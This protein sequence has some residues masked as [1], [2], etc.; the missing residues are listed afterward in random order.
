MNH[1]PNY[2]LSQWDAEDKVLHTDFNADNVKIDA[3]LSG[4]ASGKADA[5]ALEAL[6]QTLTEKVNILTGR[7][8]GDGTASRTISLGGQPRAVFVCPNSGRTYNSRSN[9]FCMG[10]LAVPGSPLVGSGKTALQIVNNGFW[11][12][13]NTGENNT[14]GAAVNESGVVYNYI[15]FL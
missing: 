7:Y 2:N 15:A 12:S 3:A 1:T 4:L 10:G 11:V 13:Q 8:T 5:P 6:A 9:G 14:G